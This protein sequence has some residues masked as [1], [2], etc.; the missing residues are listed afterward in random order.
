ME[1]IGFDIKNEFIP[2]FDKFQSNINKRMMFL[3][4]FNQEVCC[5]LKFSKD[6]M[7]ACK[8]KR[9]YSIFLQIKL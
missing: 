2:S 3:K 4:F 1:K 8:K 6:E 5:D 9:F 7:K